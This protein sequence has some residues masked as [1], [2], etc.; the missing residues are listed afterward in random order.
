MC[1]KK[2]LHHS[3]LEKHMMY[4]LLYPIHAIKCALLYKMKNILWNISQKLCTKEVGADTQLLL[5]YN[6]RLF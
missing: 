3:L 5:F 1:T 6:R 4:Q 2:N